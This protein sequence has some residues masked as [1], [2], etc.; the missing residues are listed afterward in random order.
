MSKWIKMTQRE[1][2]G[3]GKENVDERL[4]IKL[5]YPL[6]VQRMEVGGSLSPW[7]IQVKFTVDPVS[8]YISGTP[9]IVVVGSVKQKNHRRGLFSNLAAHLQSSLPHY[10]LICFFQEKET[11]ALVP[12]VSGLIL[13][14]M[15][16]VNS[17]TCVKFQLPNFG[18]T[19]HRQQKTSQN[20]QPVEPWRFDIHRCPSLFVED[21][22]PW[23]RRWKIFD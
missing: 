1:R 8:M 12:L 6:W 7:T 18:V 11:H 17:L 5:T 22:E 15:M 3:K 9:R 4:E 20:C 13:N 2:K 21:K 14:P 23:R 16:G 10:K 19:T